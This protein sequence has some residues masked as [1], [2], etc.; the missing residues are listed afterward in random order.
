V[1]VSP[2]NFVADGKR[3]LERIQRYELPDEVA[4]QPV[5]PASEAEEPMEEM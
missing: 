3:L 2:V 4:P 1:S 5:A